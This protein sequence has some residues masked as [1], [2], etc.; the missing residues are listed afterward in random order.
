VKEKLVSALNNKFMRYYILFA[1]M[2]AVTVPAF[3]QT[4]VPIVVNTNDI[5]TQTNSWITVFS[6]IL[7]IGIGISI[8]LAILT[9]IGAQILKAFRGGRA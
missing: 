6:P 7:A 5:F 1:V 3:A 8:A 4:P 9:F 2:L